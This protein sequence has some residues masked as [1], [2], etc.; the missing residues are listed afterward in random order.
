MASTSRSREPFSTSQPRLR[1]EGMSTRPSIF[2]TIPAWKVF[3]W[4]HR[5][6]REGQHLSVSGT[7]DAVKHVGRYTFYNE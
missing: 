3:A 1:V 4:G 5:E 2:V 7:F 6:L